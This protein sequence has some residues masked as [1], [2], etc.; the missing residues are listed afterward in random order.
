MANWEQQCGLR[1][2]IETSNYHYVLMSHEFVFG[3]KTQYLVTC[4]I[5]IQKTCLNKYVL[6]FFLD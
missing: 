4:R 1:K 5:Y 6:L 2:T 3:D